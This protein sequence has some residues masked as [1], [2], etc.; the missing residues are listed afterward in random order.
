[1][2]QNFVDLESAV[3]SKV[4]LWTLIGKDIS[5][6]LVSE[7]VGSRLGRFVVAV[8]VAWMLLFV[9]GYFSYGPTP[10]HPD[11]HV[12]VGFMPG[13]LTMYVAT[14]LYGMSQTHISRFLRSRF[15]VFVMSVF[16]AWIV[17]F[18]IGYCFSIPTRGQPALLVFGGFLVGMVAMH[19]ATRVYG[20]P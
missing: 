9:V 14:R 19:I 3:G 20:M 15:D 10:G 5:T 7:Y 12:F 11:T 6:S 4:G 2:L 1:M 18:A 8:F 17:L 13:M 16:V